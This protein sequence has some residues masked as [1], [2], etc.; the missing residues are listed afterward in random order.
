MKL[1]KLLPFAIINMILFS[2]NKDKSIPILEIPVESVSFPIK[3][4]DLHERQDWILTGGDKRYSFTIENDTLH[5]VPVNAP[6]ILPFQKQEYGFNYIGFGLTS[7]NYYT[8]STSTI[9]RTIYA[10]SPIEPPFP[11][12]KDQ[13]T[14]AR[15][16]NAD[17]L[18]AINFETPSRNIKDARFIHR[19]VLIDFETENF[20]EDAVVTVLQSE[21]T[22]PFHYKAGFYKAIVI[23]APVISVKTGGETYTVPL[24]HPQG[25]SGNTHYHFKVVFNAD[26]KTLSITNLNSENWSL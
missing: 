3:D 9:Q 19:N 25:L 7:P 12:I 20:P 21:E 6:Y 15:L 24:T 18:I 8:Q 23:A 1:T 17:A 11:N 13:S 2:C 5:A 26:N 22:I 10:T 16:K 14:E 4:I